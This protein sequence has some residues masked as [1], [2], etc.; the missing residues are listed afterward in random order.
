MQLVVLEPQKRLECGQEIFRTVLWAGIDPYT[1]SM[2]A[3]LDHIPQARSWAEAKRVHESNFT[4]VLEHAQFYSTKGGRKLGVVETK[5]VGAP[6]ALY[7]VGCDLVIA[8]NP[9][10][11]IQGSTIRK[12]T[13]AT[14]RGKGISL[15][16][17][18]L[19]ALEAIELLK[20]G[21]GGWGGPDHGTIIGS[22]QNRDSSIDLSEVVQLLV[23]LF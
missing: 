7:G 16:P 17:D 14:Q 12:S 10:H 21:L 20:S 2:E 8:L 5:W 22:P 4:E 11:Q 1:Q 13:V 19:D 6:G 3:I 18:A 9:A 23:D 15:L